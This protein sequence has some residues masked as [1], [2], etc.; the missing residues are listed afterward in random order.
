MHDV[1][2]TL[3][4][5]SA[6]LGEKH[7]A[8][9]HLAVARSLAF[10]SDFKVIDPQTKKVRLEEAD[11]ELVERQ[12]KPVVSDVERA[13]DTV[14]HIHYE[15]LVGIYT[16]AAVKVKKKTA[17]RGVQ[18][19]MVSLFKKRKVIDAAIKRAERELRRLT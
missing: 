19:K 14:G 13:A 2:E 16:D 11:P 7:P 10:A 4:E 3:G 9:H 6:R 1:I 17:A 18:R 8:V 5:V 12:L 15:E